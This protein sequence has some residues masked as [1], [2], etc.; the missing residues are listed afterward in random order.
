MEYSP[1]EAVATQLIKIFSI[2]YGTQRFLLCSQEPVHLPLDLSWASWTQ[3]LIVSFDME[4]F[5]PYAFW[6]S[7]LN[8]CSYYGCFMVTQTNDLCFQ[9]NAPKD[10]L[11]HIYS[12][13]TI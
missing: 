9:S 7:P 12:C 8:F 11:S 10:D 4:F 2:F 13:K 6:V 5:Y 3:P 1:W